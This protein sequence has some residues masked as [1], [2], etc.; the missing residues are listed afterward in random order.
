MK[1]EIEELVFK[2]ILGSID[3]MDKIEEKEMKKMR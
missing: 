3:D 1:T 2:P